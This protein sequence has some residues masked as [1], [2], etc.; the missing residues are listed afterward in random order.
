MAIPTIVAATV[1]F[2]SVSAY[3]QS[4]ETCV[5]Y[6]EADA[7]YESAI[8][9]DEDV[10]KSSWEYISAGNAWLLAVGEVQNLLN[11]QREAENHIEAR[12]LLREVEKALEVSFSAQEASINARKKY[13]KA[14]AGARAK[15]NPARDSA[16]RAAYGGPTSDLI[17]TQATPSL[18]SFSG[19]G[20]VLSAT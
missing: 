20:G 19:I 16:Y 5:A 14:L 9:G 2:L 3:G 15:L 1:V 12:R 10:V 13:E 8:N 17:T 11:L 6:M 4:D 18:S 7:A